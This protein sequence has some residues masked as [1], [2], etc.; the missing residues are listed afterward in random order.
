[1]SIIIIHP[2]PVSKSIILFGIPSILFYLFTNYLI[3]FVTSEFNINPIYSWFLVGGAGIFLPLFILAFILLKKEQGDFRLDS[4]IERLRLTR[5]AKRE[6]YISLLAT[7][8][9]L[10]LSGLIIYTYNFISDVTQLFNHIN[11]SPHFLEF[12]S[13]DSN[14]II[15]LIVW[16]PFFLFNILG[17]ELLWRGFILPGQILHHGKSAWI[18]NS[19]LWLLFHFCFGLDLILFLLPIFFILPYLVQRYQNTWIGIIIHVLYN[20]PIFI[21][22]TTGVI[23]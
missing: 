11:T 17:E 7:A 3:S 6:I 20:G 5:P 14:S 19:F 1:M 21:L 23:S 15:I 4:I 22:I 16:I 13:S 9:C 8:C 2:I 12:N 18:I 10:V